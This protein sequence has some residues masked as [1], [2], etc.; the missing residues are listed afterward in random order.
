MGK[1]MITVLM[2]AVV[3]FA[4]NNVS[5]VSGLRSFDYYLWDGNNI[6]T[7]IGNNATLVSHAPMGSAG[8]EWPKDSGTTAVFSGG[9]WLGAG[10]IDGEAET[11]TAMYEYSSE[12][13]PG[14]LGSDPEADENRI[15]TIR[16]GDNAATPDWANWP[17]SQGAPWID[18]DE[19][20][21][22]NPNVDTPLSKGGQYSWYIINDGS[23]ELH[24]HLYSTSPLGVEVRTA[25]YGL[26]VD[27]M[28]ANTL[29]YEWNIK[30]AG[31]H[32]LDSVFAGVWMD[33]DI[34]YSSDDYAGTDPELEMTYTYNA[35]SIDADYGSTPPA[36]GV[37]F[38]RTPLVSAPGETGYNA[39]GAVADHS[40]IPMNASL[41]WRCSGSLCAPNSAGEAFNQMN[42][43]D[44]EGDSLLDLND[45]PT[46]LMFSGDPVT[47]EGWTEASAEEPPGDRYFL[48]SAGPF[49]L[50]PG[51]S[52]DFICAL[53]L[54]QG[55][56]HLNA[57]SELRSTAA[58]IKPLWPQL[59]ETTSINPDLD[60]VPRHFVL[61]PAF[62]NPFNPEVSLRYSLTESSGV[63]L[64]IFNLRGERVWEKSISNQPPG[65][66]SKIWAG[67]DQTGKPV[68]SG[69][70]IVCLESDGVQ[71]TQKITLIR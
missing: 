33:P 48:M 1:P 44:N 25:I 3:L 62:P 34:G 28:L 26:D 7:W 20:G 70:Y 11:R 18:E 14:T 41:I 43:L 55:S 61:H 13:G 60:P 66:Y 9:L 23:E 29:F 31:E 39:H 24:G 49:S 16:T 32:Q 65:S 4:E 52:Q 57:I 54:A 2:C 17:V 42:G 47:G 6:Q 38:I 45:N 58:Y 37:M 21:N 46:T 15:Y 68:G 27:G 59:F 51:E 69:V 22:W 40:N 12:W 19:D 71:L 56:T 64:S 10:L 50:A 5:Q 8:L 30:N 53:M 36:V 35:D 67:L 63:N